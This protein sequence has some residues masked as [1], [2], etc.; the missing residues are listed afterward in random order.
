M[1]KLLTTALF[2]LIFL[3]TISGC[4]TLKQNEDS[5]PKSPFI[6]LSTEKQG[7]QTPYRNMDERP[8]TTEQAPQ[9]H[10]NDK[11]DKIP[12]EHH[13]LQQTIPDQ[14]PTEELVP[15][16]LETEQHTDTQKTTNKAT[17]LPFQHFKERWNAL[18]DEQSSNLY[19]KKLEKA[20]NE[21]GSYLKAHLSNQLE[22]H[23]FVEG[24][25]IKRLDI[26][27]DIETKDDVLA[28]LSS[29]EQVVKILHPNVEIHDVDHFFEQIGVGPDADLTNVK[30]VSFPYYQL[31]YTIEPTDIGYRFSAKPN[32]ISEEE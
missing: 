22:L 26:I 9:K 6:D 21:E 15:D 1:S 13:S 2:S 16:E 32:E 27:S 19:I 11:M 5:Q 24:K 29:W 20:S 28:M 23:V 14:L 3:T 31:R 8:N 17:N 10:D 4:S 12:N 18:S 7:D 30:A 25:F